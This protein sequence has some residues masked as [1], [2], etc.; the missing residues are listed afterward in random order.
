MALWFAE[1]IPLQGVILICGLAFTLM[2]IRFLTDEGLAS[3]GVSAP[4]IVA[5]WIRATAQVL[6]L[7]S[8]PTYLFHGPILILVGTAI[9]RWNLSSDWRLTWFAAATV[10]IAGGV[11][12]G[13]FVE[14][15]L[16]DWRG[17]RLKRLKDEQAVGQRRAIA[18]VLNVAKE[19][20][21]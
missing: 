14:R 21:G 16:M 5:P 12:L 11:A 6:G 20:T 15:P 17:A 2:L 7:A 10:A 18:G 1:V 8:Y 3:Q 19:G 4:P 13:W 9:R